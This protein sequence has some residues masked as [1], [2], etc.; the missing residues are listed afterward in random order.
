MQVQAAPG[1]AVTIDVVAT[2]S[3]L[4]GMLDDA[5]LGEPA[6]L[7]AMHTEDPVVLLL[8]DG[9]PWTL[10]V[11]PLVQALG[12]KQTR[13]GTGGPDVVAA[14][15]GVV[16]QLL[17]DLGQAV[18]QGDVVIVQEAM[19]L[20]LPLVATTDGVVRAIHCTAGQIVAKGALLVEIEP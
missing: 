12:A 17:V 5:L 6:G 1:E 14:M 19:K 16:A 13:D 11:R 18:R 8:S 7:A 15:P 9:V 10:T 4:R 2:A 3:G 20:M